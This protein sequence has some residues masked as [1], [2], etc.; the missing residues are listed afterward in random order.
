MQA[1]RNENQEIKLYILTIGYMHAVL[2]EKYNA[3]KTQKEN[4]NT[5]KTTTT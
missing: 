2:F 3:N 1:E 5:N 4:K